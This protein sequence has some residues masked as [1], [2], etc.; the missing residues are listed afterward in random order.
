MAMGRGLRARATKLR[1]LDVDSVG[2]ELGVVSHKGAMGRKRVE[3]SPT[4]LSPVRTPL[5]RACSF[6]YNVEKSLLEAL[7]QEI[8]V[9]ILCCLH[10]EDL[11]R[12]YNVSKTIRDASVIAGATHFAFRTPSPK[13]KFAYFNKSLSDLDDD[14]LTMLNHR[15]PRSGGFAGVRWKVWD[16]FKSHCGG[17]FY[18]WK[19]KCDSI[20]YTFF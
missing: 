17:D 5:K 10:H 15:V 3:P 4:G 16:C 19:V 14:E 2:K 18:L 13:L 7:P 6:R 12:V 11:N 9:K 8:L 20:V 1:N